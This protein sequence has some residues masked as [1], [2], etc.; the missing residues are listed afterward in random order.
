MLA[1]VWFFLLIPQYHLYY[2]I[3]KTALPGMMP[4]FD[5][6]VKSKLEISE[7]VAVK[8]NQAF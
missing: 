8:T 7:K 3:S 6:M 1:Q 4:D 2:S 5:M